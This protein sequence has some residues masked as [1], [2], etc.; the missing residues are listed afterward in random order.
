MII[1]FKIQLDIELILKT[2]MYKIF[3][4]I[5]K[6][7]KIVL[8]KIHN[9]ILNQIQKYLVNFYQIYNLIELIQNLNMDSKITN[10]Q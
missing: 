7:T 1:H 3:N 8:I 4:I 10:K 9:A 2:V 6:K 5:T